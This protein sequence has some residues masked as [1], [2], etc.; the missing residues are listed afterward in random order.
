[1]ANRLPFSIL[2]ADGNRETGAASG[3]T[4]SAWNARTLASRTA[5]P[6]FEVTGG[7]VLAPT[8]D[9]ELVG[10]V[11][12]IDTGAG[13]RQRY[14]VCSSY[15]ASSQFFGLLFTDDAGALWSGAAPTIT[16]WSGA[17]TPDVTTP[18]AGVYVVVPSVADMVAEAS[19][20]L[21]APAG[22]RPD[23]YFLKCDAAGVTPTPFTSSAPAW[24]ADQRFI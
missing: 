3:C 2:D 17:T 7:Y 23:W 4:V 6:V 9:D 15:T 8:D 13:R 24:P 14:V 18:G 10:T 1:M 22:A 11:F 12:L 19:G 20:T 5:A 21:T 16:A